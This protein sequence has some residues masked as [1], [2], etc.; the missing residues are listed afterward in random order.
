MM[1][2]YCEML[3]DLL[4]SSKLNL[5]VQVGVVLE[6]VVCW[7]TCSTVLSS[8]AYAQA[9]SSDNSSNKC[10]QGIIKGLLC[11]CAIGMTLTNHHPQV[12]C[13]IS[14]RTRMVPSVLL[15]ARYVACRSARVATAKG[16][17]WWSRA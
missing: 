5:D 9:S 13:T 10:E 16:Q 8:W 1:E 2:I 12:D 17:C 15:V 3:N 14:I 7:I 11:W 6:A 4:D